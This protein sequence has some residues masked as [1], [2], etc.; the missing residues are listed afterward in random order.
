[1]TLEETIK[2]CLKHPELLQQFNRLHPIK[3]YATKKKNEQQFEKRAFEFFDFIRDY[4][5]KPVV[6]DK[7]KAKKS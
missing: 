2:E 1:M 3:I 5:W 7:L 6:M 4:I